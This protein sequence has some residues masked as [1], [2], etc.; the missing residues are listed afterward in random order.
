M[1]L[2][3][4]KD[5]IGVPSAFPQRGGAALVGRAAGGRKPDSRRRLN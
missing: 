5:G 3:H 4:S 1:I 2:F